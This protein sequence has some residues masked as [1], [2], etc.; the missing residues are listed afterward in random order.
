M[1]IN[2]PDIEIVSFRDFSPEIKKTRYSIHYLHSY[3]AQ[4]IPHIPYYFLD[5][6]SRKNKV[7]RV[8]DPF[9]G[10]GTVL[11]EAYKRNIDSIGVDINPIATLISK[12]KTTI[13]NPCILENTLILIKNQ[14]EKEIYNEFYLPIFDNLEFWFEKTHII[15]LARLKAV[16]LEIESEDLRNFFLVTYS[17]IIKDVSKADPKISVPVMPNKKTDIKNKKTDAKNKNV[18]DIFYNKAKIN[19]KI[20]ENFYN[21][22]SNNRAKIKIITDDILNIK[23]KYK[24]IDMVITSPPYISAQKYMRSTRLEAYWLD[25]GKN[26]QTDIDKNTIGSERISRKESKNI[27]YTKYNDLDNQIER[28]FNINP[29]RAAIVSKYF[30]SMKKT[31]NYLYEVLVSNG[32]FIL[33]IGNNTVVKEKIPTSN[34]IMELAIETG[35]DVKRIMRDEIRNRG[36]MTTRNKTAGLIDYEW[37][38]EMIKP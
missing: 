14:F 36:L 26:K 23:Y 28:I 29:D 38:I 15:D 10:T 20:M 7:M 31:L 16:I 25:Y 30:I 13:L 21:L 24:N 1:D 4:L 5:K 34:Y 19:I 3:P 8:F 35:F 33:I 22:Y 32:S 12:V 18:F 37:V 9:C 27:I 17:S 11:V 6:Y 2:I